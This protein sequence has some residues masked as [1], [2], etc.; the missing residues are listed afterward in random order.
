MKRVARGLCQIGIAPHVV[1]TSPLVR[2]RET[3]DI[4]AKALGSGAAVCDCDE[5]APGHSP[6]DVLDFLRKQDSAEVAVVGHEPQ[7]GDLV[8]LMITGATKAVVDMK[9][10]SAAC[11][12]FEAKP[13]AGR[14]VLAWHVVPEVIEGLEKK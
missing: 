9:K 10:A 4:L 11:V 14:G 6:K 12:E 3:A 1:Y 8:A 7:L 2:A 5:L 13:A